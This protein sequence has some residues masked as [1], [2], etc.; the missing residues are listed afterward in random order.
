MTKNPRLPDSGKA[1]PL[2]WI[3]TTKKDLKV[4]I[5]RYKAHLAVQEFLHI[6]GVDYTDIYSLV[7]KFVSIRIILALSV[8]LGLIIHTMDVDTAFLNASLEENIWVQISPGTRLATGNEGIY[9]LLKSLYGLKQASRCWNTLMN[10]NLIKKGFTRME[11]DPCIYIREVVVDVNGVKK[12]QYQLVAL[13]VDDLI[14]AASTK[15]LITDLEGELESRFKMKKLHQIKQILGMGIHL[16]R[17]STSS[18]SLNS[19]TLR[20]L[21]KCSVSTVLMNTEY[22]WMTEHSTQGHRC[23][24]Q[25]LLKLYR[26]LRFLILKS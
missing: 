11:A 21:S 3:Y 14:I 4:I 26:W 15:N 1:L 20:S 9:K 18:I 13:Y 22:Q 24:N 10:A 25:A 8:Q 7:A 19:S 16:T 12:T 5:I 17:I 2:K 6:F 23:P